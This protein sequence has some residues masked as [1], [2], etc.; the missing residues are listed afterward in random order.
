MRRRNF[1]T[2]QTSIKRASIIRPRRSTLFPT[3]TIKVQTTLRKRT[4]RKPVEGA[5]HPFLSDLSSPVDQFHGVERAAGYGRSSPRDRP[6]LGPPPSAVA[7]VE[8]LFKA[9]DELSSIDHPV[10]TSKSARRIIATQMLRA[11]QAKERKH[12]SAKR[13][14][15]SVARRGGEREGRRS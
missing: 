10:N 5:L 6:V 12:S 4:S 14:G 15:V 13:G 7:S 1:I 8:G 2:E 3:C 11:F 9:I